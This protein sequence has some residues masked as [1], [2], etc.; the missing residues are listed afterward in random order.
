MS[1]ESK[2]RVNFTLFPSAESF[3]V[4]AHAS[5]QVSRRDEQISR[6]IT[7]FL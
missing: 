3:L 1:C 7:H 6:Q 2:R 4:E 5:K